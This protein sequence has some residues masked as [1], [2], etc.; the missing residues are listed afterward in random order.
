MRGPYYGQPFSSRSSMLGFDVPCKLQSN[1]QRFKSVT[2]KDLLLTWTDCGEAED[3]VVPNVLS[4]RDL[5]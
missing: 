4:P 1:C 5:T 2:L 3:Y